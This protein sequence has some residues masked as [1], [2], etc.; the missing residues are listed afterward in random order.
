[1]RAFKR[2]FTLVEIMVVITILSILLAIVTFSG[3]DARDAAKLTVAEQDVQQLVL[4]IQLYKEANA[5]LPA[6]TSWSITLNALHPDYMSKRIDVDA[7]GTAFIYQNNYA[8]GV[9]GRGSLIC[10]SGPDGTNDTADAELAA[11]ETGGDDICGFIF[12]ED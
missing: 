5:E 10:S 8:Q 1:M 4:A 12:D 7:W 2:G 6:D 3:S 11:Y 9:S